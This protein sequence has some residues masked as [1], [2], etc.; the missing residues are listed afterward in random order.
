MTQSRS[1]QALLGLPVPPI[2]IGLFDTPPLG[3][4]PWEGGEVP[5]GCAFWR[6]AQQGSSF[7][8]VPSDH[9]NCAVGA[10]THGIPLPLAREQELMQTVGFMV[11][12]SYIAMEEVPG[13]PTLSKTPGVIAYG[14]ADDGAFPP[15]VVLV[16][17]QPAS[18]MLLYE[19]AIVAGVSNGLMTTLGRP[20]C[21]I[22][23]L[24]HSSGAASLS[25]GCKGN[26]TFT[27]LPDDQLYVCI[28]G[29]K[30]PAVA[31][32]LEAVCAANQTLGAYYEAK[33]EA[34]AV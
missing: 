18:A 12:N 10:H 21:A 32:K 33:Q 6:E 5:A 19:A 26:R 13:I 2:S 27:G 28:P 3:L 31:E 4:A 25:F 23:P 30:W 14:P 29:D 7:Y 17:A 8:T 20:G 22:L 9:Y 16:A 34:L 15:T 1:V 24:A 11:E